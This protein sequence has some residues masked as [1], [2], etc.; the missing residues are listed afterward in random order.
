M[1]SYSADIR[2]LLNEEHSKRKQTEI[3]AIRKEKSRLS[4]KK[5]END[6]D[7]DQNKGK[8]QFQLFEN[9]EAMNFEPNKIPVQK[10]V[11]VILTEKEESNNKNNVKLDFKDYDTSKLMMKTILYATMSAFAPPKRKFC[12]GKVSWLTD[13]NWEDL[14]AYFDWKRQFPDS[15]RPVD[16]LPSTSVRQAE[17][18]RLEFLSFEKKRKEALAAAQSVNV[19]VNDED[20]LDDDEDIFADVGGLSDFKSR[21]ACS[22]ANGAVDTSTVLSFAMKD[23]VLGS[24][25]DDS[26]EGREL[27]LKFGDAAVIV[28]GVVDD[29]HDEEKKEKRRRILEELTKEQKGLGSGIVFDDDDDDEVGGGV[30]D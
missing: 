18:E 29:E 15:K 3:N 30:S 27:L 4:N 2:R 17:K 25:E 16:L 12:Q 7:T 23:G 6:E 28:S 21:V 5:T 8:K 19:R 10:G 20:L 14:R 26:S 1:N 13:S 11:K 22:S 24:I 9:N